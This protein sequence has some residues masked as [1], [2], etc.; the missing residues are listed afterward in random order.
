MTT[1]KTPARLDAE[2]RAAR[3][4]Y[5]DRGVGAGSSEASQ[6]ACWEEAVRPLVEEIERLRGEPTAHDLTPSE[7]ALA[8]ILAA[9]DEWIPSAADYDGSRLKLRALARIEDALSEAR[10]IDGPRPTVEG[11][12]LLARA[13]KAGVL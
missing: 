5:Q 6:Q 9:W 13:R 8:K 10:I 4:R 7:V 11:V 2:A 12:A 1:P 3:M